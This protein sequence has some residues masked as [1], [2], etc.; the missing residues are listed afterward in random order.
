M[1][2]PFL[3][4]LLI[5]LLVL[6][7]AVRSAMRASVTHWMAARLPSGRTGART[8]A[9]VWFGGASLAA[10][11]GLGLAGA[12]IAA[13]GVWANAR[14]VLIPCVFVLY[15][16][17]MSLGAPKLTRWQRDFGRRLHEAGAAREAAEAVASVARVF[18]ALGVFVALAC[19]GLIG[20]HVA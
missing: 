15:V 6:V 14:Y 8:H 17:L 20:Y 2:S 18:S 5:A 19:I 10:I 3:I 11:V 9:I 4:V 16:P 13:G 12:G 1:K 7:I